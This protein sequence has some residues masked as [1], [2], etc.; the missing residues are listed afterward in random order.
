MKKFL[1]ILVFCFSAALLIPGCTAERLPSED[2]EVP[3]VCADLIAILKDPKISANSKEKYD[4]ARKLVKR[5]DLTFTR[6]TKTLN[7]L[8]HFKDALIDFPNLPDRTITFNY[9]YKDN[10]IRFQFRT[11]RN[12]VLRVDITEK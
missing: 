9:Q 3:V 11:F 4:A 5:V 7:D 8:F 12:F 10:Y 6:E 1:S 2:L